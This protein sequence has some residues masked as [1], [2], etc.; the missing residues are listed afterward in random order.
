MVDSM[1]NDTDTVI[2][3]APSNIALIKYWGKSDATLNWPANDSLSM[4]LSRAAT[5]TMARINRAA[6][7]STEHS[8]DLSLGHLLA[9]GDSFDNCLRVRDMTKPRLFLERLRAELKPWIKND[10][11][12]EIVTKN[13]FPSACGIASSASG[14]AALTVAAVGVWTGQHTMAGL[15][16]V[17]ISRDLIAAWARMGSGSAC[18]SIHGGFVHWLRGETAANQKCRQLFDCSHWPL[19]DLI[20]LIDGKHKQVSSTEGHAR[21]FSSP[22]MNVRL[23]GAGERMKSLLNALENK[24][25]EK[26]GDIIEAEALEMHAVMMTATQPTRY[27]TDKT[28]EFLCWLRQQRSIGSIPAWFTVDAG[29]NPH[30]I[31]LPE[32]S[33]KISSQIKAQ[34]PEFSI[35]SDCTGSGAALPGFMPESREDQ[36][37]GH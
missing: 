24:D 22:L 7:N 29:P 16:T 10:G 27:F 36:I 1:S 35:I 5:T 30:L 20:V 18:R 8:H 37:D 15:E 23:A 25:L 12:L 26:L 2:A 17:G 32:H 33:Q 11:P 6:I 13:S 28:V 34:F 31:C 9:F 21:A 19:A 3:S 4:T 14:Y